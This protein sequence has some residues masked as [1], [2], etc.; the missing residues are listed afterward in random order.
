[1]AARLGRGREGAGP[2][3]EA[4]PRGGGTPSKWGRPTELVGLL[5]PLTSMGG[6]NFVSFLSEFGIR[7]GFFS[8]QAQFFT[9]PLLLEC[10][11]VF[12]FETVA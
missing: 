12:S 6:A 1:M 7:K 4:G 3:G 9:K 8:K 10:V 11:S 2:R 5:R